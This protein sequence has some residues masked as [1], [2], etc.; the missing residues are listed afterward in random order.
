MVGWLV[1]LVWV[2]VWT[3]RDSTS[4]LMLKGMD[5]SSV[6][7]VHC[8]CLSGGGGGGGGGGW[9]VWFGPSETARPR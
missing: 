2:L 7:H 5:T 9:L 6:R 3:S 4:T 8:N 1:G